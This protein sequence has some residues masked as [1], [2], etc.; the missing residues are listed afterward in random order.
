MRITH[1]QLS[2]GTLAGGYKQEMSN[3]SV[4][5]QNFL[6]EQWSTAVSQRLEADPTLTNHMLQTLIIQDPS[7]AL[8]YRDAITANSVNLLRQR[9]ALELM[10]RAAQVFVQEK[11]DWNYPHVPIVY[12]A[13]WGFKSANNFPPWGGSVSYTHLTLPTKA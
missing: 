1:N 2:G 3:L 11:L 7:N 6:R 4:P 12:P 9:C 10:K 8:R 5:Y 13:D